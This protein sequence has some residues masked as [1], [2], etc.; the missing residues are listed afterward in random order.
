MSILYKKKGDF[1]ILF[2]VVY[3][4]LFSLLNTACDAIHPI[5]P[6]EKT[7]AVEVALFE[8]GYGIQWHQ[9]MAA[10]YNQA[11]QTEGIQITM[12]GDPRV[13]EKMRPRFLR[14][15]P[16]DLILTWNFPMWLLIASDKLAPLDSILDQP[17]YGSTTTWRD[18]F[19]P[20]TLAGYRSNGH[21]YA[22]P[23]ALG[24]WSCWYDARL[25]RNQGW[26][27][28]ET[29]DQFLAL[30]ETINASGI[31]PIAF[32]GKYPSY[33]WF[34]FVSLIQRCGGLLAIN[35]INGLEPGAFSHPDVVWAARLMQ[36]MAIRFFQK[37]A[38]SMSH[39]ESQ[40]QFVNNQAAF[41]FN[42][43][44]L[45]NEMKKSIPANF[46]MRCFG[47]PA[48]PDG[49]GNPKLIN[50]Q[51]S[52]WF[53][54]PA[55]GQHPQE[56]M[57]FLRYLVSPTNA[58]DMGATIGIISPLKGGT[59]R[60]RISPAQQTLLDMI[61]TAPGIFNERVS[62]LLLEWV[63]QVANPGMAMLLRNEITPE[64]YCASL[65]KGIEEALKNKDNIIPPYSPYVPSD[66]GEPS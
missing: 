57:D 6:H 44:W 30:C 45:E 8:G 64:Q 29:W 38:M 26:Q 47:V 58:P 34:T 7:T 65:D 40:L 10:Q 66:Y 42:G 35:R 18:L 17:S 56:A 5:H 16:P 1:F 63:N 55:N 32:M 62:T 22:I 33:G 52:E 31:A 2:C 60:E 23:S 9:K 50:G 39:T 27:L 3:L 37:G 43:A 15:D 49:K 24:A 4:F 41:I 25:F 46:E 12:W 61:N 36:D 11:H 13:L 54:V 28:P 53:I 51:G 21:V 19:M 20:G 48:V 14:G 59:S